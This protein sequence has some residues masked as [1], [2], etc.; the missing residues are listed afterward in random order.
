MK[1]KNSAELDR[2]RDI[3]TFKKQIENIEVGIQL[4]RIDD[5]LKLT[6]HTTNTKTQQPSTNV[7][8]ILY[9]TNGKELNSAEEGEAAFYIKFKNYSVKIFLHG[10]QIGII[11]FEL[12]KEY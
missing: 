2:Q 7:K 10:K 1:E 11:K 8:L 6:I 4:E 9:S 5:I 3:I 12:R